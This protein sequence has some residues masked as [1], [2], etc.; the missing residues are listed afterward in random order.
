MGADTV[1]QSFRIS[2]KNGIIGSVVKITP[3]SRLVLMYRP[4]LILSSFLRFLRI[5]GNKL[6]P[7]V[8]L[9]SPDSALIA[10]KLHAALGYPPLFDGF[11]RRDISHV[12]LHRS[13]LVN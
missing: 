8:A 2:R 9:R 10:K 13:N 4:V 3:D 1:L 7:V 11:F 12:V 5:H 6:D